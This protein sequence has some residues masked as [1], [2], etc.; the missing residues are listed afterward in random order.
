MDHRELL[1]RRTG[2]DREPVRGQSER[3]ENVAFARPIDRGRPHDDG[4]HPGREHDLLGPRLRFAVGSDRRRWI[5]LGQRPTRASRTA[6]GK[7][8]AEHQTRWSCRHGVHQPDDAAV[9]HTVV[10]RLPG[11]GGE[12]RQ[13]EHHVHAI[14]CV[15]HRRDIIHRADGIRDAHTVQPPAIALGTDEAPNA[16]P[17][18]DERFDQ[19]TTD[20]SA[21]TRDERESGAR[22]S[23]CDV[24]SAGPEAGSFCRRVGRSCTGRPQPSRSP[25]A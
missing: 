20:E 21:G 22:A 7:T 6:R 9:I 19:V 11:C 24:R 5:R 1:S 17:A 16:L 8:R 15:A 14:Q 3:G 25:V 18:C 12:A 2:A 23:H 4:R 10:V 13:M